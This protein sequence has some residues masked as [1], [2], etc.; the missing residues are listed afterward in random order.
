MGVALATPAARCYAKW[1]RAGFTPRAPHWGRSAPPDPLQLVRCTHECPLFCLLPRCVALMLVDGGGM[2][3]STP[4]VI[5]F[6]AGGG[7]W[8]PASVPTAGVRGRRAPH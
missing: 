6:L 3:S 7:S 4:T 2:I 5:A 8:E 1:M